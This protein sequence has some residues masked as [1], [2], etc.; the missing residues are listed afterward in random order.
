LGFAVFCRKVFSGSAA[1]WARALLLL[2]ASVVLGL[3]WSAMSTAAYATY[4]GRDLG[5]IPWPRYFDWAMM[6]AFVFV[7]WAACYFGIRQHLAL[8][9]AREQAL[10]RESL[11]REA[12]LRALRY[13]LNPHFL[14]NSLNTI[15]ALI[16]SRQMD[17]AHATVLRLS[18]FLRATLEAADG[19]TVLRDELAFVEHY[20]RIE[21]VRFEDRLRYELDISPD[22]MDVRVPPLIIQPLV[23]NAIRHGLAKTV[24][25][26]SIRISGRRVNGHVEIAVRDDGAGLGS[27]GVAF[28]VGLANTQKRLGAGGEIELRPNET[29]GAT[30]TIRLPVGVE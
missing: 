21:S 17:T 20:L 11:L 23:E 7:A 15:G 26:G 30:A 6:H 8:E 13:Q 19:E 9:D 12:E 24:K 25:G 4:V 18:S 10:E 5:A 2:V 14:F 22:V 29:G 16:L 1:L 3:A 28:G 27:E